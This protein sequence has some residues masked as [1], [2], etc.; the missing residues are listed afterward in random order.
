[1]P[2]VFS[3]NDELEQGFLQTEGLHL[4][5]HSQG[6]YKGSKNAFEGNTAAMMHG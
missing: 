1:M 5:L 6:C 3:L 2:D 4:P